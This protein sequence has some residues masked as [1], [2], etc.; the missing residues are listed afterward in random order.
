MVFN[1][2]FKNIFVISLV[3]ISLLHSGKLRSKP[4]LPGNIFCVRN[5]RCSVYNGC[6]NK[7]LLLWDIISQVLFIHDSVLFR[8]RLGR[9]SLYINL[10]PALVLFEQTNYID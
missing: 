4:N 6:I 5:R 10:Y 3:Y 7:D 2:T 1:A 8:V 9:V